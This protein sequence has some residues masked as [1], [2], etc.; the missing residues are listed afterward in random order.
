MSPRPVTFGGSEFEGAVTKARAGQAADGLRE[1]ERVL[2]T[3][4][5]RETLTDRAVQAA[6]E[7]GRQAEADGDLAT[8]ERAFGLATRLRP[9]Y[10]DL[11]YQLGCVYQRLERRAEAR[12]AFDRALQLNP[13]YVAA[14]VDRAMLDAREGLVGEALDALTTL[15]RE[16]SVTDREVFEQGIRHVQ[17]ADWDG[18]ETLLRRALDLVAPELQRRMERVRNALRE[19]DATGAVRSLRDILP[20]YETYPDLHDLLGLA[21][22]RLAHYDDALVCFGRALELNPGFHNARVHLAAALDALGQSDQARAQLE[23]V[24]GHEPANADAAELLRAMGLRAREGIAE[25]AA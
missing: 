1:I 11:Q 14:R 18:A 22:L 24:L 17:R 4:D 13:R 23:V 10:A 9:K 2:A 8:A 12:R 3:A 6:A 5:D 15:G 19:G 21:E 20:R 16:A 25:D 7:V